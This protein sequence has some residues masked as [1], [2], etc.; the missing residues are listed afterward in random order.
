VISLESEI[1]RM[2]DFDF[3][4]ISPLFFLERFLRLA[5][6]QI[7]KDVTMLAKELSIRARM[8]ASFL[9]WKPSVI[10]GACIFLSVSFTH[11]LS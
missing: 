3:N 9:E 11:E 1:V 5:D 8:K 10:A 2:L 4:F 7:D 6:L